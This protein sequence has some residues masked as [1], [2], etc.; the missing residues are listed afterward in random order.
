MQQVPA[1][2]VKRGCLNL[3]LLLSSA[4]PNRTGKYLVELEDRLTG[5]ITCVVDFTGTSWANADLDLLFFTLNVLNRYMPS[6]VRRVLILEL[7]WIFRTVFKAIQRFL[8]GDQGQYLEVVSRQELIDR[9][10]ALENLPDYLGGHC[11]QPYRGWAQ[12]AP[13]SQSCIEFGIKNYPH[14]TVRQ[15]TR[16]ARIFLPFLESEGHECER[17]KS[18][19]DLYDRL[20]QELG[21]HITFEQLMQRYPQL[22]PMEPEQRDEFLAELIAQQ[23]PR[24]QSLRRNSLLVA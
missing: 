21:K 10:V 1:K 19:I 12:A 16:L 15:M 20:T 14:Y 6:V 7:P 3:N 2:Q 9:Y 5:P 13:G 4:C 18:R 11:Q 17:L 22:K 24:K 8:P 23:P